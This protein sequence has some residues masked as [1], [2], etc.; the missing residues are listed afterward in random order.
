MTLVVTDQ[1]VGVLYI[2]NFLIQHTH[3]ICML[4]KLCDHCDHHCDDPSRHL[5]CNHAF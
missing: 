2:F 1:F 3:V 5:L 4:E